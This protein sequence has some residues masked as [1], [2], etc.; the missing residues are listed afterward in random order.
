MSINI[1][2]R[3]NSLTMGE[4]DT[5]GHCGRRWAR[6]GIFMRIGGHPFAQRTPEQV[7]LATVVNETSKLSTRAFRA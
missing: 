5:G 6:H 7:P 2:R 1:D 3:M 4:E